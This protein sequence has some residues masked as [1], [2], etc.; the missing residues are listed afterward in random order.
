L[1]EARGEGGGVEASGPA[2]CN[3][4]EPPRVAPPLHGHDAYGAAHSSTRYREDT[5]G[6]G[7]RGDAELFSEAGEAPSHGLGVEL[8]RAFEEGAGA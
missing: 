6:G 3:E 2:K 1:V 7:A 4:G 8:E 5:F